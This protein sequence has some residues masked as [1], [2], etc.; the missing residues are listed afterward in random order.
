MTSGL[1]MAADEE[2]AM[3]AVGSF[4]TNSVIETQT[5]LQTL[6]SDGGC[7][8]LKGLI[9]FCTQWDGRTQQL[10]GGR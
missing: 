2:K 7:S 10:A 5:R 6:L 8:S 3:S 4:Q 9:V 1:K